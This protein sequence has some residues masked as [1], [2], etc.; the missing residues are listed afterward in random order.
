MNK[1]TLGIFS[2]L[3]VF[4]FLFQVFSLLTLR[5]R[6]G[7]DSLLTVLVSRTPLSDSAGFSRLLKGQVIKN[8]FLAK[9]NRLGTVAVRFDN[10]QKINSDWVWFRI[11]EAGSSQWYYSQKYNSDQFHPDYYFTFGF[12]PIADSAAKTYVFELESDNGTPENSVSLN[13]SYPHFLSKYSYPRDYLLANRHEIVPFVKNKLTAFMSYLA[14]PDFLR[15]LAV[16]LS[17]F[18]FWLVLS[19]LPFSGSKLPALSLSVPHK[20]LLIFVFVVTT[21]ISG[22]F[23]VIGVDLHHDGIL[24]KPAF[25][26]ASGR[27]LFRESFTQ[28]GALTT[29]IQGVALVIFGK[30]LVVIKLLTAVFYGLNSL[31]LYQISRKILPVFLALVTVFIWLTLAPFYIWTFLPWSSVYALFF[32]LT[33]IY[34]FMRSI[35]SRSGRLELFSGVFSALTFWC[36]QPV[37]VFLVLCI[38]TYLFIKKKPFSAY[39]RGVTYIFAVFIFW[40]GINSSLLDWFKQSILFSFY[41]GQSVGDG[42]SF[43]KLLTC[44]FPTQNIAPVTVWSPLPVWA[45]LPIGTILLLIRNLHDKKIFFLS[46]AGLFSWLQY[47]PVSDLRHLYWAATP[48]FPLF[49]L[50]VYQLVSAFLITGPR[51]SKSALLILTGISLLG[52]FSFDQ[53]YRFKSGLAKITGTYVSLT[54]PSVLKA[55]RLTPSE[56]SFYA[57]INNQ[58][59]DYF[60]A[61]PRGNVVAKGKNALYLTFDRRISNIHPMYINLTIINDNVYQDYPDIFNTYVEKTRPLVLD[62]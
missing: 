32:Q 3:F 57:G 20:F 9:Y 62:Y 33:A 53:I 50:F 60:A 19:K 46:L 16:S 4:M 47:Y 31:L 52:L 43:T 17:P 41:W 48:L 49:V 5:A 10:H 8:T 23:S 59:Q 22:I 40:L 35:D 28:Y 2:G 29:L 42:F 24:F 13:S 7:G 51:L 12:P 21:F 27:T 61:H 58:I 38:L 54:S 36:R 45:L 39:L 18:I 1:K 56:A 11:R 15:V 14:F 26:L 25:D 44:L 55:L 6:T 37:G 30:Y 34:L